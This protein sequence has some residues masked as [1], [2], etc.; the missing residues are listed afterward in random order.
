MPAPAL[1]KPF[2]F[3]Q[4]GIGT[5]LK[6]F[7]LTMPVNQREYFWTTTEVERLFHDLADSISRNEDS[8]FLGTI[9]TI[10]QDLGAVEVI[11]GQQRLATT[12]LL[13]L[14]MANY[15]FAIGETNVAS[16]AIDTIKGPGA[17]RSDAKTSRLT[18][19]KLDNVLFQQIMEGVELPTDSRYLSHQ[20]LISAYDSANQFVKLI[21]AQYEK[22]R[23]REVLGE[24]L[25]FIEYQAIVLIMKVRDRARAFK[26]FETLNDRG[27]KVV[28]TDMIK[29]YLYDKGGDRLGECESH[30]DGMRAILTTIETEDDLT[31]LFIR[32]SLVL[33]HG[34]IIEKEIYDKVQNTVSTPQQACVFAS[35]L[36]KLAYEYAAVFNTAHEK[37]SSYPDAIETYLD[38]LNMFNTKPMRPLILAISFRFKP[39]EAAAAYKAMVAWTVRLIIAGNTRSQGVESPLIEAASEVYKGTISGLAQLRKK[40]L[41]IIPNDLQFETQFAIATSSNSTIAAFYLRELEYASIKEHEPDYQIPQDKERVNLEHILPINPDASWGIQKDV[42]R[43]YVK[44]IGNLCLMQ[45]KANSKLKSAAFAVKKPVYE[46]TPY[47]ITKSVATYPAWNEH[48]IIDRQEKL[49]KL[50]VKAWPI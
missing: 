7:R 10:Q 48:S 22:K 45:K 32:H 34:Y 24:W 20:K 21:V 14:A 40:L 15:L 38:V 30:W 43:A 23:H 2:D 33:M 46:S 49:A 13:V 18:L 39:N 17:N 12:T 29:S 9:V 8:Y 47:A 42:V 6:Q 27:M 50:A 28:Q 16:T 5:I 11:D 41:P 19:N 36:Q 37:W 44:R 4:Q 26:M 25:D 35:D 31:T 3:D 1:L